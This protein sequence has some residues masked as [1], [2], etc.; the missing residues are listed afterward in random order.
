MSVI[1]SNVHISIQQWGYFH[2]DT[3]SDCLRKAADYLEEGEGRGMEIELMT[4]SK[5]LEVGDEQEKPKA[6]SFCVG[7]PLTFTFPED[8]LSG[9]KPQTC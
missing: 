1:P 3:L 6:T 9:R 7:M 4:V 2:G 5:E 8:I